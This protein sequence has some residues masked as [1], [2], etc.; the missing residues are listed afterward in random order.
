M[1]ADE[2][3]IIHYLSTWGEQFVSAKEICR[4]AGSKKRANQDPDWALPV[5]LRMAGRHILET[6]ASGRYRIKPS[7]RGHGK[8]A[9]SETSHMSDAH[10]TVVE[11]LDKPDSDDYYG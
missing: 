3:D 8:E 5:L 2:R 11:D 9:G 6:D 10:G 4:R 7:K 1:D